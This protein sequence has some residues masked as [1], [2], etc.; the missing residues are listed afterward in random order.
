MIRK[1]HTI[2]LEDTSPS[3][4]A[5]FRQIMLNIWRQQIEDDKNAIEMES[6]IKEQQEKTTEPKEKYTTTWLGE[7]VL[8]SDLH[9]FNYRNNPKQNIFN[10]STGDFVDAIEDKFIDSSVSVNGHFYNKNGTFEG[11]VNISNNKGSVND[12]YVCDGKGNAKD[13][14]VNAIKLDISHENFCYIAGVINAEDSSTFESAAATTQA[15][16]NAVKFEKGDKLS[17]EEQGK[18]AKKLLS[19]GYSTATSKKLLKDEDNNSLYKNARKGLIHVLLGKK[20][21]SEGAVLWD[22]IDFADKGITHNKATKEG[23]IS[24]SKELWVK[25]IENSK[26]KPDSKGTQRLLLHKPN[27][28][29]HDKDKTKVEALAT[30]PF[31]EEEKTTIKTSYEPYI[32]DLFPSQNK[33]WNF[34]IELEDKKNIDYYETLG[35]NNNSGRV[36]HKATVVYG[37]HIF[38]KFYYEHPN[39]KGYL[40]KYYMNHKL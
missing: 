27:S 12:V 17:M 23:G 16:F 26:F 4:M 39:N 18:L 20:D 40:W 22:G 19:T 28:P 9:G 8:N 35:T 14:F 36:L 29:A 32:F 5:R 25:F 34:Q 21:Y 2:V 3:E 31:E 11:K 7:V 30:I 10:T 24:I 33:N 6:F 13:T 15:T 37:G 1:N 38:W